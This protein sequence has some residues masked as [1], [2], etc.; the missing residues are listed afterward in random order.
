LDVYL[1][2]AVEIQ[3]LCEA[4]PKASLPPICKLLVN[5]KK[6]EAVVAIIQLMD[7]LRVAP[8]VTPEVLE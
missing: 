7:S 5:L 3:M 6:K 2:A 8:M 4:M 1:Q